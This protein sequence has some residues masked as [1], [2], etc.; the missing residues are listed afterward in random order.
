MYCCAIAEAAGKPVAMKV[1]TAEE[2]AS[3]EYK[4]INMTG[5]F[6]LLQT[7]EGCLNES[8]AIAKFLAHGTDLL[9]A[10]EWQRAKVDQWCQWQI[11]NV[12]PSLYPVMKAIFGWSEDTAAADFRRNTTGAAGRLRE[13]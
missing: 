9:G 1:L 7:P 4:N 10:D 2:R 13:R 11:G 3:A 8:V 6:P 12:M 5:K